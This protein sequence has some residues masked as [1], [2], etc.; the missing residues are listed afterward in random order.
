VADPGPGGAAEPAEASPAVAAVSAL[1]E[2]GLTLA[3]AESLTAGLLAATVATVPGASAVLRGGLVVYATE[4][5]RSLAGVDAGLLERHGAVSAE[6]AAALAAGAAR[7][8]GADVGVGLTG[9]AGPDTQEG[10]P[11]GTVHL[12]LHSPVGGTR[13]VALRLPG[14]RAA[15]REGAVAAAL[16]ELVVLAGNES[17]G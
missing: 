17:R 13:T 15:V 10:H 3:T 6:T 9:V 12:G 1:R 7:T 8:C 14:D 5:K 11:A 4:L 16:R 2:A